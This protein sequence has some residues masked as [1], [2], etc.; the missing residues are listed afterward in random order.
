[1]LEGCRA[2]R[3]RFCFAT[4]LQAAIYKMILHTNKILRHCI[5]YTKSLIQFFADPSLFQRL[6]WSFNLSPF[7]PY[8]AAA[9]AV[10]RGSWVGFALLCHGEGQIGFILCGSCICGS[11]RVAWRSILNNEY[12]YCQY[13]WSMNIL[14]PICVLDVSPVTR[15][16]WIVRLH[17]HLPYFFQLL[18]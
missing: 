3:A 10:V 4:H 9:C 12:W 14:F 16:E 15:A 7:V 13:L 5:S 18:L 17:F 11:W 6:V 8:L 2:W 1:M